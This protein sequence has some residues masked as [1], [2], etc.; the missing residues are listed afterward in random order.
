MKYDLLFE[1]INFKVI[2]NFLD[3]EYFDSLVN[4][5]IGDTESEEAA[6]SWFFNTA[7]TH[8]KE[9]KKY[10][11]KKD[12]LFYLVHLM[13]QNNIPTSVHYDKMLPLLEKLRVRCLIRMK[14]NLYPNTEILHENKMHSDFEFPHSGAILYLNTCDGYTKL[15][16]GKK[17]DSVANR[18]LLF[19]SSEK[20]CSTTTTDTLARINININFIDVESKIQE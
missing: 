19:N 15:H 17:I 10:Q 11:T 6:V 3:K 14:A 1:D 2:D 13:Y 12:K 20:H 4:L 5:F 18:V 8:T 16:D 7:V 9:H